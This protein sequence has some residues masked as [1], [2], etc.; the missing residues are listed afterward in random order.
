MAD[1]ISTT[2]GTMTRDVPNAG[3]PCETW[4]RIYGDLKSGVRPLVVLHGGPGVASEYVSVFSDLTIH[5]SI[6]I[7]IYDQLGCGRSTHL[8]DKR[9]DTDFWSEQLFL[10]ELKALLE[11]LGIY[12]DY[13]LAGHSWGGMLGSRH[14]ARQPGGL[15]HLVIASSPTS[16]DLWIKAQDVLRKR[17]PQD[18]QDALDKNERD[19]TTDSKEY[20]DAVGV[21][22][23]QFLCRLNPMPELLQQ[24]FGWLEKDPTVYFTM[25][26]PSEFYVTGNLKEWSMLEEAHKISVPTLLT[27]GWNDEAQDSCVYPFF[28][29][30][31]RVRW[32]QFAESSHTAHFEEREKFFKIVGSFLTE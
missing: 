26:G 30:I 17:L 32:V 1:A 20:H 31:P 21:F 28:K 13:D 8:P 5:N 3:K 4:Y 22:Y 14:A 10:D 12:N 9:G 24:S 18:V 2:E 16:M 19:G 23:S 25:N 15:K 27:N 7:V 6:P 29:L 11:H